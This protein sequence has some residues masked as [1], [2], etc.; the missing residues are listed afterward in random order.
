MNK[1][2][3]IK[4]A[5]ISA[6]A[7]AIINGGI[8]WIM[9]KGDGYILLTQD[10]I[11]SNTQTVFGG[12]VSLATSLAFILTLVSFINIK[13]TNKKHYFPKIL[14]WALRNS[15][16]AFGVIVVLAIL[17]QR[18]LGAQ[19]VTPLFSAILAGVVAGIVG[20]VVD[21]MTKS[22]LFYRISYNNK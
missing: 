6:I 12:I 14:F 2:D 18:I 4:G 7:N 8:N 1:K 3:I 16:M 22:D 10:L 17:V 11:S 15:F 20:G 21:Y 13:I 19:T 9:V 5:W